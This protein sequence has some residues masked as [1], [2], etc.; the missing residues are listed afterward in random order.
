MQWD[1]SRATTLI[2]AVSALSS[3][4]TTYDFDEVHPGIT[5]E[6]YKND[7]LDDCVI[8]ARAHHT[9]RLIYVP[10]ASVLTISD[11]DITFEYNHET[12]FQDVRTVSTGLAEQLAGSR[13][14]HRSRTNAKDRGI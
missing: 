2:S 6:M 11:E 1:A 9:I 7:V 4:P 8:A 3:P 13:L 10:G 14:E 12:G 5:I